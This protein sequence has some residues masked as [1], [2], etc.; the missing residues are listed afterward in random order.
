MSKPRSVHD[1]ICDI[2]EIMVDLDSIRGCKASQYTVTL[3]RRDAEILKKHA[4]R[5][6]KKK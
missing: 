1:V 6:E 3:T 4:E 2:G 5:L